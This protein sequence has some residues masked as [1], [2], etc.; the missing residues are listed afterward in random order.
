MLRWPWSTPTPPPPP[1]PPPTLASLL[2]RLD[3]LEHETLAIRETLRQYGL[4]VSTRIEPPLV[5]PPPTPPRQQPLKKRTAA[6]VRILDRE[7]RIALQLIAQAQS[8]STPATTPAPIS[9][10]PA[11][12]PAPPAEAPATTASTTPPSTPRPPATASADPLSPPQSSGFWPGNP[13]A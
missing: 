7:A 2:A 8:S 1:D 11:S 10:S 13:G 6:D 9:T 12:P 3:Y 4:T 5:Y